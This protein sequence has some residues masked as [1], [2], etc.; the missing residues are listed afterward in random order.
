MSGNSPEGHRRHPVLENSDCDFLGT[1]DSRLRRWAA[2]HRQA[3]AAALAVGA[4]IPLTQPAAED[5]HAQTG[6]IAQVA[7]SRDT[8]PAPEALPTERRTAPAA[9]EVR[10]LT[11][12]EKTRKARIEAARLAALRPKFVKPAVGRFTSGFGARW[13]TSHNGIDI[14]NSI[15]TPIVAVADGTVVESGPASGFGYWVQIRHDDGTVTVYGHMY[16]ASV[17]AGERVKAGDQISTIGNNGQSTGPHLHFEVW[18]GG[19]TKVDPRSWLSAHGV[20]V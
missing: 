20:A 14:A 16:S 10:K 17:S 2:S 13:G 9:A 5:V 6:E 4:L 1:G 7:F 15:G 11:T 12:A 18:Q 19:G 3:L 8:S